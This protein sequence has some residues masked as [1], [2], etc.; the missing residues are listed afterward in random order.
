MEPMGSSQSNRRRGSILRRRTVAWIDLIR[1]ESG[2]DLL[3]ESHMWGV[4]KLLQGLGSRVYGFR[5]LGFR[6][7]GGSDV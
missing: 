6:V 7:L 5:V 2:R 1:L 4:G 3:S